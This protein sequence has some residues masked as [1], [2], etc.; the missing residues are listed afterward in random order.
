MFA[1]T[2]SRPLRQLVRTQK[3]RMGGGGC[4]RSHRRIRGPSEVSGE[5]QPVVCQDASVKRGDFVLQMICKLRFTKAISLRSLQFA[6]NL[7]V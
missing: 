5:I 7:T 1:R 3:R 2:A 4:T 6:F